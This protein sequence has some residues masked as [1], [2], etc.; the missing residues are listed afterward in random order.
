MARGVG[1]KLKGPRFDS[2][3]APWGNSQWELSHP[4]FNLPLMVLFQIWSKD[5]DI[6]FLVYFQVNFTKIMWILRTPL[7]SPGS[8]C[9]L[10][11]SSSFESILYHHKGCRIKNPWI[12]EKSWRGCEKVCQRNLLLLATGWASIREG[13]QTK[14]G[15]QGFHIHITFQDKLK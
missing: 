4:T 11:K 1:Y 7:F 10:A 8:L 14:K 6:Y 13:E 15:H 12:W 2:Q 9:I 3:W 5:A